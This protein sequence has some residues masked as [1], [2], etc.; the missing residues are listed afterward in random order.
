MLKS[1]PA[2]ERPREKMHAYGIEHLSNSELFAIIIRTGTKDKSALELG[3]DIE[4]YCS[5]NLSDLSRMTVSELC[6]INGI[7]ETKA[8]QILSSIELGR[9]MNR[10]SLKKM[11]KISQPRDVVSFFQT[12]LGHLK[13]EKFVS[14]FLNVKNEI[15]TW[16]VI[17]VGSLNASIVHPRE[18]F[19][20]G[21]RHS[22]ASIIVL[23]NHP[24]GHVAPSNEDIQLT[25]RLVDAG[26]LVGIPIIDHLIVGHFGY[27]SFKE[28][29]QI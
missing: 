5:N 22:A 19:N 24:S 13:V 9:R 23:H 21:I 16:E 4:N 3:Y 15:I 18:V 14:I 10:T 6:K 29:N 17:S 20:R 8:S 1:L 28:E 2:N 11:H 25:K 26:N 12:E 27:Y 7:G